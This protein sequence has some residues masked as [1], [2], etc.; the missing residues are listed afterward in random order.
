M[1]EERRSQQAATGFA[2]YLGSNTANRYED[3]YLVRDFPIKSLYV[4]EATPPVDELQTFNAVGL[5]AL[6]VSRHGQCL[7]DPRRGL[8][9]VTFNVVL[10]ASKVS[11]WVPEGA[12]NCCRL[13]FVCNWLRPHKRLQTSVCMSS[14]ASKAT[15]CLSTQVA[16]ASQEAAD[17]GNEI[18]AKATVCMSTQVAQASQ[19]A[20]DQARSPLCLL[21]K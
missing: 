13:L 21:S 11:F 10:N 6:T 12:M 5:S 19:Q 1:V 9:M 2:Y 16:Q 17:P 4:E 20:A 7:F 8:Y 3:G 15:V 14:Y 18:A